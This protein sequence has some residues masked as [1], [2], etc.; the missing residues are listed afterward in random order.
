[1]RL[2]RHSDDVA[3]CFTCVETP[4]AG[5]CDCA[6]PAT[7]A[8]SDMADLVRSTA[9]RAVFGG[10]PARRTVLRSLG[11]AAALSILDT[12]MP[13][14]TLEAMAED[15]AKPEK[16]ELTIGFIDITCATPL[17]LADKLGFFR[18]RPRR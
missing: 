15:R 6:A 10:S 12:V 7:A 3:S 5:C 2:H 16:S 17:C 13:L 11:A 18:E 14:G 8:P 9:L 4:H 1:M